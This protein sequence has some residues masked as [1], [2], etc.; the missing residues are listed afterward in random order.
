MSVKVQAE[1]KVHRELRAREALEQELNKYRDY[2]SIQEQEIEALRALL[3]KHGIEVT[4]TE[5]RPVSGVR[6]DV[7]VEVNEQSEQDGT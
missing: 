5:E 7:V 3:V 6:M 4:H 2:C 1:R